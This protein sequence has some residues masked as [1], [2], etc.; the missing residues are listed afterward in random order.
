[1]TRR[2]AKTDAGR[3]GRVITLGGKRLGY[4]KGYDTEAGTALVLLCKTDPARPG[5]RPVPMIVD[6]GTVEAWVTAGF[7]FLEEG[8]AGPNGAL[9]PDQGWAYLT[10]TGWVDHRGTPM[11]EPWEIKAD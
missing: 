3:A 5:I 6:D 8:Q 9:L 10:L 4:C 11:L 2:L 7:T 1:M